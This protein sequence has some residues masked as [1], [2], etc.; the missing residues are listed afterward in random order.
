MRAQS[1]T[2]LEKFLQVHYS[3]GAVRPELLKYSFN[4]PKAGEYELTMHVVTV[5][6]DRECLFR[7]NRRT[8]VDVPLPYTKGMW[9]DTKPVKVKLKEGRN[10]FDITYKAPNKGLTVKHF[11][12][13]PVK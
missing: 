9:Q 7:F 2:R 8:L 1:P 3:L 6:V 10:R 11:K 12:L 5:T 13:T 4:A